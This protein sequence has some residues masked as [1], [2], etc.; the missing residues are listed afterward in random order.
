MSEV[1][2]KEI[3]SAQIKEYRA[4]LRAGLINDEENFRITPL[5]DEKE[6][7]PTKDRDDSFTFGAYYSGQLA[8]V[9][10]FERDGA[11][12]EKLRHK[13]VLFRMYVNAQYRGNG[14]ARKLIDAL[15]IRVK[16][17]R[18]IEQVNLTVIAGNATAQKLYRSYGF[19]TFGVE[20]K[21]IK[22]K[23]K[24]FDEEQMVLSVNSV[25]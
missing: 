20:K 13:G 21:A 23:G 24:Y 4:F 19:V 22:W 18:D 6:P 25:S 11:A 2:I 10:S 1:T 5:D 12:R 7:F 9:V 15:L 16:G 14:I 3:T 8:G 17:L